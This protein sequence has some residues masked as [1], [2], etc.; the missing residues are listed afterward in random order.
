MSGRDASSVDALSGTLRRCKHPVTTPEGVAL[1]RDPVLSDQ[2]LT[3]TKGACWKQS[4]GVSS[5]V[6]GCACEVPWSAPN[7]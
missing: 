4:E 6:H 5:Y 3:D 7:R 2:T 1:V